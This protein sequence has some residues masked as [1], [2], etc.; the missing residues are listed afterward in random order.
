MVGLPF[1]NCTFL[2]SQC[3]HKVYLLFFTCTVQTVAYFTYCIYFALYF[4]WVENLIF[5]VC[6]CY[7][8][9]DGKRAMYEKKPV[10]GSEQIFPRKRS[11]G[12]PE[13][14]SQVGLGID[15]CI[16]PPWPA[17]K[18][19]LF[20]DNTDNPHTARYFQLKVWTNRTISQDIIY[21]RNKANIKAKPECSSHILPVI[22]NPKNRLIKQISTLTF[23]SSCVI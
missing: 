3:E 23:Q 13:N 2:W 20:R 17:V 19:G 5:L 10:E 11:L 21:K 12:A 4:T 6:C 22:E 18:G 8:H 7:Y 9:W 1:F 14:R 16:R 15:S